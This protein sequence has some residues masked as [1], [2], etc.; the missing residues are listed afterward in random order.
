MLSNLLESVTVTDFQA[1]GAYSGLDLTRIKQR[2]SKLSMAKKG[3]VMV[4]T[5][6]SNIIDLSRVRVTLDE[7]MAWILDLLTTLAHES[8]T[9]AITAP[10]LISAIHKSPQYSLSL[11]QP[12]VFTIRS[13]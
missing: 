10:S 6:H 3:N 9:Q 13:L 7:V 12:A 8:E 2:I 1:T 4:R 5:N 11:F